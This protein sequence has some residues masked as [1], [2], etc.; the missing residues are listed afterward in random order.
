MAAAKL[1]LG[2]DFDNTIVCYDEVFHRLALAEGLIPSSVPCD[3]TSVRDFLRAA[4]R[5]DRWTAMQALAYGEGMPEARKFPG[6]LAFFAAC[7]ERAVRVSIISHRTRQPIV[8]KPCDLHAAAFRWLEENGFVDL[9]SRD[10][11]HFLETRVG[12]VA[13]VGEAG[14]THFIDD[15][16]EFLAEPL[17]P[18]D[19]RRILFDPARAVRSKSGLTVVASW[20]EVRTIFE[21]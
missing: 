2:V 12:K 17:L 14:C 7:A 3:K 15:L 20:A 6:V 13:R 10:A 8:G 1:H 4:G 5:E 16:P 21:V 11:I 9:V 18:P 19:L